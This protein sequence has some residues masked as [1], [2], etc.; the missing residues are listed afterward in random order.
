MTPHVLGIGYAY[1]EYSITSAGWKKYGI[2][3]DYANDTNPLIYELY[4][5]PQ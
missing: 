1:D 4:H 3:F 5:S 2:E